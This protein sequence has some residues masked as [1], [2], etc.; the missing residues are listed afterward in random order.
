MDKEISQSI[1]IKIP[2]FVCQVRHWFPCYWVTMTTGVTC[3]MDRKVG[4]STGKPAPW[5]AWRMKL[6]ILT[7]LKTI[8]VSEPLPDTQGETGHPGRRST[9]LSKDSCWAFVSR[10]IVTCTTQR[11]EINK[12]ITWSVNATDIGVSFS[13]PLLAPDNTSICQKCAA[14]LAKA[15]NILQA[16]SWN[17]QSE[18]NQTKPKWNSHCRPRWT[19]LIWYDALVFGK[20]WK[21][22]NKDLEAWMT[23]ES[24]FLFPFKS[25]SDQFFVKI[26]SPFC[27]RKCWNI[28][29]LVFSQ[30]EQVILL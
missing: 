29:I 22:K 10:C 23:G 27:D 3:L 21:N 5:R 13:W 24:F 1:F 2:F 18:I 28:M 6:S 4:N 12:P 30:F 14:S 19:P 17:G 15:G 20:K 9:H 25:I 8:S 7:E 11:A 26:W 16:V